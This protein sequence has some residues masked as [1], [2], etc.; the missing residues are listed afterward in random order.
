MG[1]QASTHQVIGTLIWVRQE[2]RWL[3][4]LCMMDGK[5]TPRT[6]DELAA[7]PIPVTVLNGPLP[8]ENVVLVPARWRPI[9]ALIAECLAS[10]EALVN[11]VELGVRV[12]DSGRGLIRDLYVQ[13]RKQ[14]EV[15][16]AALRLEELE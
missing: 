10:T 1:L 14:R 5:Y 11:R 6:I 2:Q 9:H 15:L 16:T 13:C 7:D 8:P 12:A 4:L 3:I